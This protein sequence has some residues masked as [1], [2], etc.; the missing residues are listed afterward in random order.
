MPAVSAD[1]VFPTHRFPSYK[2]GVNNEIIDVKDEPQVSPL[3]EAVARET[4]LLLEQHKRLSVRDL[5]KQ[6]ELG[7]AFA[8][9]Q[10]QEVCS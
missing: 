6:F 4:A 10:S 2:I 5:A 8:A 3:R 9:R 1:V 7:L